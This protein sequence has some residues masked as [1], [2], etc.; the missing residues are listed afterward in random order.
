MIPNTTEEREILVRGSAEYQDYIRYRGGWLRGLVNTLED[1]LSISGRA[2]LLL[3]LIYTTVKAG[4]TLAHVST[5]IWLDIVMLAFQVAGMEG[6]IPG[7]TRIREHFL[8]EKKM[9][10][11][12]T[13]RKVIYSSRTLS[14]LTGLELV[15]AA[16]P[17]AFGYDLT[18]VND[19]YGKIL[20]LVRLFVITNFLVAMARMEHKAPKVISPT[21]H[22]REQAA[23][24]LRDEQARTIANLQE[25]AR[26]AQQQYHDL[27]TQ[28]AQTEQQAQRATDLQMGAEQT[29]QSQARLLEGLQTQVRQAEQTRQQLAADLQ[30]ANL[31]IV[32]LTAK[33]EAAKL[34]TATL[35][36]KLQAANLQIADLQKA[37]TMQSGAPAKPQP[38]KITALE[39]ATAQRV[40]HADVLA[41]L[42][43]H[44]ALK[45]AEVA[46]S[47]GISERKVYEALAWQKEQDHAATS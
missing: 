42:A 22:A 10:E 15:L 3:F 11:A 20:L 30:T 36:G 17:S 14:V 38:A 28:F 45:R 19:A 4:M 12:K 29:I 44:P 34:Q 1:Y 40:S 9:D 18:T 2:L 8:S 39:T 32:D 47:L 5:P 6:S 13:I 25:Q 26:K 41:H 7:L 27:S 16:T 37:A 43:A 23:I 33:G 46:A 24:A 31:Q 21:A 35:T